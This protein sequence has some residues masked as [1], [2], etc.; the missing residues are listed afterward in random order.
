MLGIHFPK[1]FFGRIRQKKTVCCHAE[2]C[3]FCVSICRNHVVSHQSAPFI[4]FIPLKFEESFRESECEICGTT[5]GLS[6][7]TALISQTNINEFQKISIRSLI[8][9]T[10]SD[11]INESLR[12]TVK[13]GQRAGGFSFLEHQRVTGF[14]RANEAEQRLIMRPFF[15]T[16]AIGTIQAV[17][18]G[19][20]L[21]LWLTAAMASML[22][23]IALVLAGLIYREALR[24]K[25]RHQFKPRLPRLGSLLN[26]TKSE[27]EQVLAGYGERF[28]R[29]VPRL[30]RLLAQENSDHPLDLKYRK[31]VDYIP[32]PEWMDSSEEEILF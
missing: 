20:M 13:M 1:L 15:P 22:A 7:Q 25:V 29:T 27:L 18:I 9:E 6:P 10:H 4:F 19:V 26:M 8:Q 16:L 12:E 30:L 31:N 14:L 24:R 5:F 11:L 21:T 2:F 23:T 28:P 3:D 32:T 17:I